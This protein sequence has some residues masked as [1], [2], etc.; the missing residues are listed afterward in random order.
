[1]SLLWG[2]SPCDIYG[3]A[4]HI[5]GYTIS[6]VAVECGESESGSGSRSGCSSGCGGR[7]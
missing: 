5:G 2:P 1:M 4:V 6:P 3:L 7:F